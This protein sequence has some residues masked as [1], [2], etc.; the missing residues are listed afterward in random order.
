MIRPIKIVC[1]ILINQITIKKFLYLNLQ[2]I[3]W[4]ISFFISFSMMSVM[5][6]SIDNYKISVLLI[7]YTFNNITNSLLK[8]YQY[9][10]KLYIMIR[11]L[12]LFLRIGL[13]I[14]ANSSGVRPPAINHLHQSI[15]SQSSI[16]FLGFNNTSSNPLRYC[17]QQ[18]VSWPV[19]RPIYVAAPRLPLPNSTCTS[20]DVLL[21]VEA[22][23]CP[24]I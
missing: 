18:P 22:I 7:I 5:C 3:V 17:G 4:F 2:C 11:N 24:V 1:Y 16:D 13:P 23:L 21:E 12:I 20:D 8:L 14:L 10:Q 15:V 19:A 6:H 9:Y